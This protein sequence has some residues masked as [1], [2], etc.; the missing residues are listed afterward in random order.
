MLVVGKDHDVEYYGTFFLARSLLVRVSV[1]IYFFSYG[2]GV[3]LGRF[4]F[5]DFT[6]NIR[7]DFSNNRT[8]LYTFFPFFWGGPGCICLSIDLCFQLVKPT[9]APQL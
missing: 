2:G 4:L 1:S 3:A 6:K 8:F 7:K 5:Y 9:A